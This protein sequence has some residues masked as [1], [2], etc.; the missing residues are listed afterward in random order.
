MAIKNAKIEEAVLY[1][2]SSYC[3]S[4]QKQDNLGD[5]W[6]QKFGSLH[7]GIAGLGVHIG[8]I[9][10]MVVYITTQTGQPIAASAWAF[11]INRSIGK[12]RLVDKVDKECSVDKNIKLSI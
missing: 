7:I 4:S 5:K 10:E 1:F 6:F 8:L 9:A 11:K 12:L 3:V 2:R